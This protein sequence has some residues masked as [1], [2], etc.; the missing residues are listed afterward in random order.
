MFYE[1]DCGLLN[2]RRLFPCI[3]KMNGIRLLSY[4]YNRSSVPIAVS[5]HRSRRENTHELVTSRLF[6]VLSG[7][8][9]YFLLWRNDQL[10]NC[11]KLQFRKRL[12]CSRKRH[13]T[14]GR[15]RCLK[16]QK[17]S[18]C[19]VDNAQFL[20]CLE[21]FGE[22]SGYCL[23]SENYDRYTNETVIKITIIYSNLIGNHK[24]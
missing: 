10:T 24:Q 3:S 17:L 4:L 22:C 11:L 15:Y 20:S 12:L 5:G 13:I 8:T 18:K 6:V 14:D 19:H 16:H 21:P 9:V 7:R 23:G 2:S 1:R